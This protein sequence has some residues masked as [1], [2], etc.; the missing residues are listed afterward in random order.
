MADSDMMDTA[1]MKTNESKWPLPQ[2]SRA[3]QPTENQTNVYHIAYAADIKKA[4]LFHW[5]CNLRCLGCLCQKEISCLALEENLDTVFRNPKLHPPQIPEQLLT[6]NE[7]TDILQNVA[8][9]EVAFEG[10]EASIDP[11]L[12]EICRWFKENKNKCRTILHTNGVYL[13]DTTY[14]DDVIISLKAVSADIYKAYTTV[15]NNHVQENFRKY[16]RSGVNLKAESVFIP[17]YIDIEETEKIATFIA[18]VDPEIPYRVDAYF[19]S[20]DNDWRPPTAEEMK[21]AVEVARKYIKTVYSTRQTKRV[22]HKEDLLYEVE[23]LY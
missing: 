20:G 9:D 14:I 2:I 17:D 1:Y 4:Y 15:P 10:Q 22:L 3:D 5:G 8:L 12:P 21:A 6:F 13:A 11:W 19:E 7:L 23:R 18:S 16:Y